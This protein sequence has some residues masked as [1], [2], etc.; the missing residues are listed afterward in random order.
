MYY[1]LCFMLDL[2]D[3]ASI[4]IKSTKNIRL[5]TLLFLDFSTI[6]SKKWITEMATPSAFTFFKCFVLDSP[7]TKEQNSWV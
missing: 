4:L 7:L 1:V 5:H 3:R 2:R 6:S